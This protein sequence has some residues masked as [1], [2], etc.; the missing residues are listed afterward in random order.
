[1]KEAA[2]MLPQQKKDMTQVVTMLAQATMDIAQTV[3]V[4]DK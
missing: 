3:A 1:M 2:T 4:S